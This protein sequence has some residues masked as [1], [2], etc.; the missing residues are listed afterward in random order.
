MRMFGLFLLALV[1]VLVA[2]PIAFIGR[3]IWILAHGYGTREL[4]TFFRSVALGLDQLGGSIL[5]NAPDWTV[6]SMTYVYAQKGYR[7]AEWFDAFINFFAG[8]DHCKLAYEWE[9]RTNGMVF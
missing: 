1:L 2:G 9:R 4:S 3:I 7:L 5:Y 8:R 6:S